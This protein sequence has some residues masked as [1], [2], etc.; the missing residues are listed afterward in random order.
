MNKCPR[1]GQDVASKFCPDCGINVTEP[2]K[3]PKCGATMTSRFCPDCGYDKEAKPQ[4]EAKEKKPNKFVEKTSS[5]FNKCKNYFLAN[6]K[7]CIIIGAT[8]IVAIAVAIILIV[9][10]TNIFRVGKVSKI[11]LGM[12]MSEVEKILGEPTIDDEGD[13][14]WYEKKVAKKLKKAEEIEEEFEF[15]EDEDDFEKFEEKY[16]KIYE[17]IEEMTY[18]FIVVKFDGD[19][20]VREVFLDKHHKY[21][22]G[23]DYSFDG[24]KEIKALILDLDSVKGIATTVDGK[25]TVTPETNKD[26]LVYSAK[27]KDGS[28]YLNSTYLSSMQITMNESVSNLKWDD[29]VAT[30]EVTKPTVITERYLVENGI[31]YK[32]NVAIMCEPTLS[33]ITIREGTTKIAD[34]F[35]DNCSVLKSISIPNSVSYLGLESGLQKCPIE[36]AGVPAQFCK[37]LS[38]ETLKSV[39]INEGCTFVDG[40]DN[41]KALTSVALPSSLTTIG[42][43]AFQRCTALKTITIPENVSIIEECAFQQCTS[44]QTIVMPKNLTTIRDY[45]FNQCTALQVIIIPENVSIIEEFAFDGCYNLKK[46][47]DFSKLIEIKKNSTKNGYVGYYASI[48]LTAFEEK[49]GDFLF[50][51]IGNDTFLT[52][53]VGA[54]SEIKLPSSYNG[55]PYKIL[56]KAFAN[57][58]NLTSITISSG[59]SKIERYAF[60]NSTLKNVIIE[61]GITSIDS[62][63]FAFCRSLTRITIPDSVTLIRNNAF[64][65]CTSLASITIG[66]S[67]TYIGEYAFSDCYSLTNIT[68]G[69]S[70]V[71]IGSNAFEHCDKLVEVYNLSSFDVSSTFFY[72]KVIHTSL[73]EPSI[74]ETVDDYIFMTWEDKYYLVGYVGNE[75][76]LT[77]PESYKEVG[78]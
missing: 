47:Y 27:F 44:L 30:Y 2:P 36:T 13:W 34:G 78:S 28:Y 40:L 8:S 68:I 62:F 58:T 75:T 66:D 16:D 51:T 52:E 15:I 25:T 26:E 77:L 12:S 21:D 5:V 6:K 23:S 3:C 31:T 63:A 14:Y 57:N 39:T 53:Y 50:A 43:F 24:K 70:M 37:L 1:C 42:D 7:K 17:E 73:D 22:D 59:V 61:N 74:L 9:T 54:N 55:Q 48:V 35:F 33:S 20:K 32:N 46:V 72:E 11:E 41:C 29:N 18:N 69:N 67:V 71:A 4:K 64:E 19:D 65:C 56:E 38:K 60:M 76:E 49:Q 10:L 45:A